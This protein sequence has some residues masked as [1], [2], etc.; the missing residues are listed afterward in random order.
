M[1]IKEICDLLKQ[2]LYENGYEYGFY[3]EGRKYTPNINNGFDSEFFNLSKTIYS[4]QNPADTM[5][6]KIGTCID[7]VMVMKTILE[8][9]DVPYKIW[10]IHHR[11][12]KKEHTILT[13]EAEKRFVYLEL[14]P[15]SNKPWYGKEILYNDERSFINEFQK[16]NYDILN[17]TDKITIGESSDSLLQYLNK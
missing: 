13:F 16:D 11:V 14:T 9:L 7:S 1:K 17:V 5:R 4:I 10:L 8:K 2:E 15:Q 12:K 6:E 3:S